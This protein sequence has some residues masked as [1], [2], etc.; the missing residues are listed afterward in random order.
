[1]HMNSSMTQEQE[2][3]LEVALRLA[4]D[5]PAHR[6]EFYKIL[7]E[8]TVYILGHS[9]S[10]T[11]GLRTFDAGDKISI[12]KWTRNDGSFVIPFFSSLEALQ[13]AIEEET[14][15]MALPA[16]SLFEMTKGSSL[17]LNP[18]LQFGKEFFANE[19]EALITNGVNRLPE[20]RVTQ[21]A[22]EVLLGQPAIYPS[23]MIDSL[24]ALLSKHSNVKAAYLTLM[25]DPSQSEKPH[26]VVG[27][28]AEGDIELVIREAGVVA[29]DTATNGEPVDL[30][31]V[32][33]GD[34]GLSEYFVRDVKPFYER[35]WG[36]KLK[37][38]LG[39]G[40]A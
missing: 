9:D 21:K 24:T 18:K 12:N 37:S 1:M 29:G 36:S 22:T 35:R 27:I 20:V 31:R 14:T 17:V 19:I 16:R 34:R 38:F 25:H 5:E 39:I 15:Y 28:E 8:A 30:I 13:K 11:N 23:K 26:L 32:E 33:Q 10:P 7:L 6:P 3:S 4:A 2:N 40:R